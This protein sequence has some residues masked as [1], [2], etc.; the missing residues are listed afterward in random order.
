[1]PNGHGDRLGV[2]L[3][4]VLVGFKRRYGDWPEAITVPAHEIEY[5]REDLGEE[6][7]NILREKLVVDDEAPFVALNRAGQV[8]SFAEVG[9]L[10]ELQ[11]EFN[12]ALQWLFGADRD[13]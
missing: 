13:S 11:P 4:H 2:K 9:W 7:F 12:G 6:R 1:M 5:L 10:K 8:A 3:C